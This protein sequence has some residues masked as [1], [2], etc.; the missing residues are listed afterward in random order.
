MTPIILT[1]EDLLA[2]ANTTFDVPVPPELLHPAKAQG[3]NGT[4]PKEALVRIRPLTIGV[5]QLIMKAAKNDP[6]MIPLLMVKESLAEPVMSLDQVRRLPIG[7][8]ELLIEH[9]REVSGLVKKK[10]R[11]TDLPNAPLLQAGYTLA[12]E[13]GWT[14]GQVQDLTMAQISAYLDL[15]EQEKQTK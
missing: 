8:V 2:G 13:F 4:T 7:L 6:G 11:L 9:I 10:K 1:A 14:P 15:L 5:Y 12:K 3:A